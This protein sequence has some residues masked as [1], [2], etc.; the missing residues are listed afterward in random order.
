LKLVNIILLGLFA[1]TQY[2]LW[3]GNNNAFDLYRLKEAANAQNVENEI[4]YDRNQQL[5]AEVIDLKSGGKTV[6][7]IARSQLGLIKEG[8]TFYQ[9][10]E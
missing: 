5:V 1:G 10:V 9:I 6:E 2:A 3:F 4:L 7:T 8:E